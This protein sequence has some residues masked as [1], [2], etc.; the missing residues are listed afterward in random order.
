MDRTVLLN[1]LVAHLE[2]RRPGHPLRVGI[3]GPSGVGKT[4]FANDL[5]AAVR[6]AGRPAIRLDSH[7][8]H[9]VRAIRY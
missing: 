6:V 7:G 9:H 3:D 1:R 5:A 2:A 4:T 8:F